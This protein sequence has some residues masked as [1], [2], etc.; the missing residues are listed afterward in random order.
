MP[1]IGVYVMK[2]KLKN[3]NG[4]SMVEFALIVPLLLLIIV[5]I[6]EFGFMFSGY[7]TLTNAS[8]E[9][10]RTIS[11]GR[12][13][14]AAILRANDTIVNLDKDQMLVKIDPS[15]AAREQGDSVTVTI[16]YDYT[17]LTPFMEAIFGGD[18]Q[19]EVST[20]MRVE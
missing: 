18:F 3:E 11:L 10:V 1:L 4:Q 14:S 15:D 7:L 16:T 19:I 8:R 13:D 5:G 17:F 9:A 12:S 2:R 20:T 6:I